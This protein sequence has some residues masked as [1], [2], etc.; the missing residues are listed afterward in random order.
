MDRPP[1]VAADG[2]HVG[3]V[4][5]RDHVVRGA[6][7]PPDGVGEEGPGAAQVP[8]LPEQQV[9]HPAAL[10]HRPIQVRPPASDA[11]VG[12][13]GVSAPPH[14]LCRTPDGRCQERP[15]LLHPAQDRAGR[16]FDAALAQQ[17]PDD[18]QR[19]PEATVPPDSG[20]DHLPGPAVSS[21]GGAAPVPPRAAAGAAPEPQP[22]ERRP[23]IP[24]QSATGAPGARIYH[25][26]RTTAE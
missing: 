8:P 25:A 5:V 7:P 12:S 23:T 3:R 9:D 15:E 11:D 20:D 17:V 18:R 22:A 10:I 14:G 16:N 6:A 24:L 13:V 21:E 26:P 2:A 4:L 19:E 1:G